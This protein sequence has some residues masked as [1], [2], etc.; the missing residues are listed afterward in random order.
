MTQI[1]KNS[2][3]FIAFIFGII[4]ITFIFQDIKS[5][6]I[7]SLTEISYLN[8]IREIEERL[9]TLIYEKQNATLSIAI[10]VS[11]DESV[12]EYFLNTDRNLDM[13][14]ISKKLRDET[15]FKNVWFNLISKDGISL[16]RSWT[17]FKGDSLIHRKEIQQILREKKL[18]STI[19]VDDY[20]IGFRAIVP[21]FSENNTFLG[22]L[23]VISHFNS[24]SK[25]L[26]SYSIENLVFAE[27]FF[28][29]KILKPYTGIFLQNYYLASFKPNSKLVRFVNGEKIETLFNT[30]LRYRITE[31]GD[32][33]YLSTFYPI[34]DENEKTVGY[35]L[36]F[37]D[38]DL[39]H[40]HKILDVEYMYN[41]YMFLAIFLWIIICYIIYSI[42]KNR[43][44]EENHFKFIFIL[45]FL[46]LTLLLISYKLLEYKF[47]ADIKQYKQK[48]LQYNLAEYKLIYNKNRDISK[49]IFDTVINKPDIL[50]LIE[51]RDREKLYKILKVN[52]YDMISILNI[53]QLHF[54]LKDSTSFLRMHR[55]KKFGDSLIGIRESVE[56]VNRHLEPFDG[57]EEG[58]IFNGFRYV[59]PLFGSVGKHI[60]SVEISFDSYSFINN[61]LKSFN[62]KISFLL[63]GEIISQ[64]VFKSEKSNYIKS[65]IDDFYFDKE[66][67]RRLVWQDKQID[68]FKNPE[69]NQKIKSLIFEGVPK[70]IFIKE[71]GEL[72]TI[73][74]IIN[75]LSGKVIGSLNIANKDE[76]IQ[77]KYN[78]FYI[79]LFIIF[80]ILTFTTI[81][82][83]R[84][85]VLKR[86]ITLQSKRIRR[87]LDSQKSIIVITDGKEIIDSNHT[88]FEFFNVKSIA[89]FNQKYEC[90]CQHFL[91]DK[92][93]I[94]G[95]S[96]KW[97]QESL[98]NKSTNSTI[99]MR[100]FNGTE[101]IFNVDVKS[102]GV[103]Y[104]IVSFF[105]IT[106]V[107]MSNQ[108]LQE[109]T[110]EQKQL[111]SLFDIG[112]LSLFKWK[113][114]DSWEIEY[115][116]RNVSSIFGY[117]QSEFLSGEVLYK[118]IIFKDDIE[119]VE[120]EVKSA[121]QKNLNSF[122]HAPYRVVTKQGKIKWVLD[123]TLILRNQTG[124]I[125]TFLGYIVDVTELKNIQNRFQLAIDGANDGLWDW[126]IKTDEIYYSPRWKNMFG[127]DE[128]EI[129]SNVE[130][131]QN[132]I[133][134]MDIE[135]V[136]QNIKNHL[137]G[138]TEIYE[139]QYRMRHKN[140]SWVWILDRGKALFEDGVAIRMV[141]F[142]TDI[143]QKKR[144]EENLEKLVEEKSRENLHQLELLQQ[145]S[146]LAAMGEMIGAI[147]HQWRQPL[148][149]L[150]INI[151]NLED[152]Y[153]DGLINEEF[154]EEFIENN[155]DII[156]FMSKTIED[157][158]NFF[159]IDKKRE[160]FSIKNTVVKTCDIQSAQ[161]KSHNIEISLNG[162]DFQISGFKSE[163]QQVILN[164]INNSKDAI[165]ENRVEHGKI[166]IELKENMV[167]IR[168]NAGGIPD[169]IID[170][171][172]E[173][174]FTTKEEGKGT[175]IGLYMS[176]MIIES[177]MG[178]KI[179]VRNI[180]DGAEFQISLLEEIES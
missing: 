46:Y 78:K 104:Y 57:F 16:K 158:R 109:R 33:N 84:E 148:N 56:Y 22:A 63:N 38:L 23:E 133:H 24:I 37:S 149:A 71:N 61:Y 132:R 123:H 91:E 50:K 58:R 62:K 1:L 97:L 130:E 135:F 32:L 52:Y 34:L 154:L 115:V 131:W 30:N 21:I 51:N 159:K 113:H 8:K 142:H 137:Q 20:T 143:T 76:Y 80:V 79:T 168:D 4:I 99:K 42:G 93:C 170:R 10:S 90:I 122:A 81:F 26:E 44:F 160:L 180:G 140:N 116:S 125:H 110:K 101:Q 85:T 82:I 68:N 74:P 127:C 47:N 174:Y 69:L 106:Q 64:K 156:V 100:S 87:I 55:P 111:L 54:H 36:L 48:Q 65:G 145:Q 39:N 169:N 152:D 40:T 129:N 86:K 119:Q 6:E 15:S 35:V 176:K 96:R 144:Y 166:D 163:F 49:F 165:V 162:D 83:Y 14:S 177:N 43:V 72:L 175:G 95:E 114:N 126:N 128:Y 13:H 172:F 88:L 67:F 164:I 167:L 105:D 7:N 11:K 124:D 134:P 31:I 155:Q 5:K 18:I 94:A 153:L 138:E 77:N 118:K 120:I 75:K 17:D 73:I 12:K 107:E 146:K 25:E 102:Y 161:L 150:G 19:S 2:F 117:T 53:R 66:I 103:G 41:L 151:Q 9:K 70:T 121:I 45:I 98:H 178:G 179:V 27:K 29:N 147:A 92:N 28:K 141:G 89:D 3:F 157:F 59:Y 173:P 112:N 108:I 136:T 60:G 171:I 139:S